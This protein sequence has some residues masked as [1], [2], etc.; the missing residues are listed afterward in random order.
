[1]N[2]SLV[3]RQNVIISCHSLLCGE[4]PSFPSSPSYRS[5]SSSGIV[6]SRT[7]SSLSCQSV[8]IS[9]LSGISCGRV[10]SSALPSSDGLSTSS[11]R[12]FVGIR[13][14]PARCLM[15]PW[16]WDG[17]LAT[18]YVT[19]FLW[20]GISLRVPALEPFCHNFFG[21]ACVCS[22][23]SHLFCHVR[24]SGS[25]NLYRCTVDGPCSLR[26]FDLV[27]LHW[28]C[29]HLG[30]HQYSRSPGSS[31]SGSLYFNPGKF[32]YWCLQVLQGLI[33][34]GTLKCWAFHTYTRSSLEVNPLMLFHRD[35]SRRNRI[36]LWCFLL[37]FLL[38]DKMRL[39]P[40]SI[41]GRPPVAVNF[42]PMVTSSNVADF[43]P[44]VLTFFPHSLP[45]VY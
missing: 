27:V 38:L 39:L 30:V 13:L 22:A 42:S 5:L 35:R 24:F 41:C 16:S 40:N 4:T 29:L 28:S 31:F 43:L 44:A 20:R 14:V 21:L 3:L 6:R 26:S 17:S 8:G 19:S 10:L 45:A 23:R 25:K 12:N 33:S 32:Y 1:M 34:G 7:Q 36:W 9:S 2:D 15:S 37:T 11:L 18:F